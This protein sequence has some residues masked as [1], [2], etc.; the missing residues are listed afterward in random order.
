MSIDFIN[1][2]IAGISI[3]FAASLIGVLVILK[4]LAL[5]SDAMSHV[6]LPGIALALTFNFNPFFGALLFLILSVFIIVA[7]ERRTNLASETIIGILFITALA[8]GVIFFPQEEHALEEALFGDI[9]KISQTETIIIAILSFSIFFITTLLFKKFAKITLSHDLAKSEGLNVQMFHI[10]FFLLFVFVIALGI[11]FIGSLLMGALIIFPAS[12]AKN[13]TKS[14]KGMIFVSL[15]IGIV[16]MVFGLLISYKLNF[17]PGPSVIL[18][19]A[20]IFVLSLIGK[21]F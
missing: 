8:L 4:K 15:I 19:N 7:I 9:S 6:A 11:K 1:I 5:V 18:V 12:T 16:T 10:I 14:L 3:I 13:L 20:I 21:I 17:D 2:L